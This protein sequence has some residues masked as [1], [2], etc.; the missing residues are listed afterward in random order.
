MNNVQ[1]L[2]V[3]SACIDGG[4]GFRAG[5]AAL[6]RPATHTALPPL[7]EK[8]SFRQRPVGSTNPLSS[9]TP[10]PASPYRLAHPP[11]QPDGPR[12]PERRLLGEEQQAPYAKKPVQIPKIPLDIASHKLY[13][14]NLEMSLTDAPGPARP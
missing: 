4:A 1:L 12:P 5:H 14:V 13:Y 11:R 2:T 8:T 3:R 7:P 6:V 9:P 10:T